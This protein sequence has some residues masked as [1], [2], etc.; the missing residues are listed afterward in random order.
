[1]G[2]VK[3]P[4]YFF[5]VF[6]TPYLSKEDLWTYRP[7]G[8]VIIMSDYD[9]SQIKKYMELTTTKDTNVDNRNSDGVSISVTYPVDAELVIYK[10]EE[11]CMFDED[12]A[13]NPYSA[14]IYISGD[15]LYFRMVDYNDGSDSAEAE[16][17]LS[18]L[19]PMEE[20]VLEDVLKFHLTD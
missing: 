8:A 11:E 2:R 16:F 10:D 9:V 17:D 5:A 6:Q 1:M 3:Q 13:F 20:W 14:G 12:C 19:L 4:K 15:Y 7:K 18:N